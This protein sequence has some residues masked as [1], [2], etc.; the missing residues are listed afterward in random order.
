MEI[1]THYNFW[2]FG[3]NIKFFNNMYGSYYT[4]SLYSNNISSLVMGYFNIF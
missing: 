4:C 2:S 3:L 1:I